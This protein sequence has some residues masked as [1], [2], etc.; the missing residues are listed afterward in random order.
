[1]AG[2]RRNSILLTF[3]GLLIGCTPTPTEYFA[4]PAFYHWK[5]D[6][7]PGAQERSFLQELQSKKLYVRYFDIV[8]EAGE[9]VPVSSVENDYSINRNQEIIPVVFITNAAMKAVNEQDIPILASR[10]FK[11]I[12]GIHPWLSNS[13]IKEIQM[14][15]D[16]TNGSR[17]KY[18]KL[19]RSLKALLDNQEQILSTTLRLHQFKNA[20]TTGIPPVDRVMLMFYNMGEV[21]E[22][23]EVNS[24]LNLEAAADYL[25][26]DEAYPL[27]MDIA[28]PLFQWGCIFRDQKLI[29]LSNN[30]SLE[31]LDDIL[32]FNKISDNRFRVIKSTYL[33]GDFLYE[34]DEIRHE[35]VSY[36]RLL[37][38]GKLLAGVKNTDGFTVAFYHL[39]SLS[40]SQFTPRE[41][42]TVIGAIEKGQ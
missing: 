27:P 31:D 34:G 28:L 11:K 17:Q 3:C 20:E 9:P 16:W 33:N 25:N 26:K 10:I 15:C 22:Y 4:T 7:N 40:L 8:L 42:N 38:A 19:L 24:I 13:A 1:M 14:D 6:Y 23:D 2:I 36:D 30:L 35:S 12:K 21:N 18:F 32:R 41:L 29:H 37:S 39:D 5:S